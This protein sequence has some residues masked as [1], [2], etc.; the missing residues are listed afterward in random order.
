MYARILLPLDGSPESEQVLHHAQHLAQTFNA[1]IDLV[2]A[3]EKQ[4]DVPGSLIKDLERERDAYLTGIASSFR[5]ELTARRIVET[6]RPAEVVI[7]EEKLNQLKS[8][9]LTKVSYRIVRGVP[10]DH[11]LCDRDTEQRHR[12][13]HTWLAG[14][15]QMAVG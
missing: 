10:S 12:D 15:R 7:L 2:S 5:G 1:S 8:E 13:V 11:R 4:P 3:V 6:G 9:G 14:R